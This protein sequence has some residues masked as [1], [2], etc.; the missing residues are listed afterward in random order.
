MQAHYPFHHSHDGPARFIF[1]F[2]CGGGD[3][4]NQYLN[5]TPY[6]TIWANLWLTSPESKVDCKEKP[7]DGAVVD[8]SC[9]GTPTLRS[10]SWRD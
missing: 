7:K 8:I 1:Q 5:D 2:A 9:G 4:L 6:E 3:I 10:V